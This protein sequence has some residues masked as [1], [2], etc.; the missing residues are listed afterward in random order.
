MKG[1]TSRFIPGNRVQRRLRTNMTAAERRLW[2]RL[3]GR[4]LHGWKFRRQHPYGDY[5]LDFVCLDALLVVE[6]DG[7]QHGESQI[8]DAVR[9]EYLRSAG[10]RVLRFWNNQVMQ[11]LDVVVEAIAGALPVITPPPSHP[12]P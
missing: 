4:Q 8:D 6:V 12:S 11:E 3:R 10:F 5:V 2:R 9:D 1:Q 7:G